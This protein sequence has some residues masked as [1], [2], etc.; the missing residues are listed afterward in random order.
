[1]TESGSLIQSARSPERPNHPYML[2]P[3]IEAA[4]LLTRGVIVVVTILVMVIS[5]IVHATWLDIFI[6][7][8][9]TGVVLGILGWVLNWFLGSFFIQAAVDELKEKAAQDS[10]TE[11]NSEN[12]NIQA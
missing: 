1:M 7:G 4:F 10:E 6:R 9:T 11:L 5:Y 3:L 12:T 8:I 2:P